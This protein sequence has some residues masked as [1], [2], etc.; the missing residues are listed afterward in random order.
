MFHS[1]M[2]KI[3]TI[4]AFLPTRGE[5]NV[6]SS[7]VSMQTALICIRSLASQTYHC[8]MLFI[9]D[10]HLH[11]NTLKRRNPEL[12]VVCFCAVLK[13]AFFNLKGVSHVQYLMVAPASFRFSLQQIILRSLAPQQI[14]A[15]LKITIP[16][17]RMK[18]MRSL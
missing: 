18:E 7:S 17:V 13:L 11:L 12:D 5:T 16:Y 2:S 14:L 1:L 9:D 4:S 8:R 15:D 10:L 3:S 6:I